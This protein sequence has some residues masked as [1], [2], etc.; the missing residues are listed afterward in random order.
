MTEDTLCGIYGL[1]TRISEESG[2]K[3]RI[4]EESGFDT[5]IAVDSEITKELLIISKFD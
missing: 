4:S 1:K 5:V 2:F 3:T